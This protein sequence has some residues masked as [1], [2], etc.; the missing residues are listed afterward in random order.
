VEVRSCSIG[1]IVAP[2]LTAFAAYNLFHAFLL[3]N[4]KPQRRHGKPDIFWDRLI[5]AWLYGTDSSP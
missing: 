1:I 5:A 3:L 2:L 4:L